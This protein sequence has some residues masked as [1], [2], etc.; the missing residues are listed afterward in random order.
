MVKQDIRPFMFKRWRRVE[1]SSKWS[2]TVG[3]QH[4]NTGCKVITG[5]KLLHHSTNVFPLNLLE[6]FFGTRSK[7]CNFGTSVVSGVHNVHHKQRISRVLSGC[8]VFAF[9]LSSLYARLLMKT[10]RSQPSR[11]AVVGESRAL[12]GSC[13]SLESGIRAECRKRANSNGMIKRH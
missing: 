7:R 1:M 10:L 9:C 11:R 3:K 4:F 5:V 8:T 13:L 2:C 12:I 6:S